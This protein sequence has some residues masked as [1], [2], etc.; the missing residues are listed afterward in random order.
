MGELDRASAA[1][2]PLLSKNHKA[3]FLS[4][5]I[6]AIKTGN[7]SV[8][9][10]IVNDST[11][12]DIKHQILFFL[13]KLTQNSVQSVSAAAG[14][15]IMAERAEMWRRELIAEFPHSP[16]GRLA[17]NQSSASVVMNPSPFWFFL[18]GL[19]SLPLL[20]VEPGNR[21]ASPAANEVSSGVPQ[22][23]NPPVTPPLS[24][25]NNAITSNVI[26][27]LQTGVFG[28]EANAQAQAAALRQAG[29]SVSIEQRTANNTQM[30]AV[31]VQSNSDVNRAMSDLRA[32]GFDSFPVR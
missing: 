24:S 31:I 17:A 12:S 23:A 11:Y 27:R 18:G 1:I 26:A 4:I 22:P 8:L 13:W 19:D 29:F 32:S 6:N 5:T 20:A 25:A 7:L 9:E 28:Q 21:I 2:E 3:R 10:T 15:A 14:A 30:W 16:E